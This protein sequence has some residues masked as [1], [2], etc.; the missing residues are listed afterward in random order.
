MYVHTYIHTY[1]C[2]V[3]RLMIVSCKAKKNRPYLTKD[4]YVH[5][6]VCTHSSKSVNAVNMLP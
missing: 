5:T 3:S 2:T 1:I 4:C 6:Y